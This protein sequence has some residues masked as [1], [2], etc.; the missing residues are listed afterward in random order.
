M[1]LVL[2]I[3]ITV[4]TSSWAL[5]AQ[6]P[7]YVPLN[8]LQGYWPFTCNANDL[9][10]N[11]Y[12]GNV[13]GATL[14][15]DRFGNPN[16]AYSFNGSSNYISTSYTGVL[17]GNP[18]AVSFWMKT[19]STIAQPA[20][21]WGGTSAGSRFDCG[22]NYLASGP[23]IDVSNAAITY[24][25]QTSTTNN[26]WHHYVFQF[27]SPILNLVEIYMDGVLLTQTSYVLAPTTSLNTTNPSNVYFG[28]YTLAGG[29]YF[30]GELDDICIWDRVLSFNEIQLLYN[31]PSAPSALVVTSSPSIVC[32][33]QSATLSA[34]G[35]STYT[36]IGFTTTASSLV[37]SPTSPTTY[38]VLGN[39][40]FSKTVTIGIKP[41]PIITINSSANPICVKQTANL[42]ANGGVSYIW[43][44]GSN[45][46]SI[47]VSPSTTAAYSVTVTGSNGCT[48]SAS[49]TQ[50]VVICTSLNDPLN[51]TS[52]I[53]LYPNPNNGVFLMRGMPIGSSI[54]VYDAMGNL[55]EEITSQN[56][57]T[58]VHLLNYPNGIYF[59]KVNLNSKV[60]IIK[61]IKE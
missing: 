11:G 2:R 59:V 48:S 40:A 25:S 12:H 3:C 36:W 58:E 35:A 55:I 16:Q 52:E 24:F 47:S 32:A 34:S 19:N 7:N 20:V 31:A 27:N 42:S 8:G 15:S 38:T 9:S 29:F 6:I 56:E 10:G 46:T 5:Q 21:V 28:A 23:T 33:G 1:K 49:I 53:N 17:G 54:N 4:L 37:V 39:C 18:R 22:F 13:V 41:N 61:V 30:S 57:S 50:S 44:V 45:S 43:N 51:N 26:L 14:T 60:N